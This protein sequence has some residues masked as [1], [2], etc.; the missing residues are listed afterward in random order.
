MQLTKIHK[1]PLNPNY[2]VTTYMP[3]I[4]TND[5]YTKSVGG[6]FGGVSQIPGKY[7]RP[8]T[9]VQSMYEKER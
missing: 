7:N 4:H 5:T 6:G 3:Y 8:V 2:I 1:V 9:S